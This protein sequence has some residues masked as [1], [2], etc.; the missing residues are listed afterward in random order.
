MTTKET[1]KIS[2]ANRALGETNSRT[3]ELVEDCLING[4]CGPDD[5]AASQETRKLVAYI[6]DAVSC[7]LLIAPQDRNQANVE[8]CQKQAVS[9]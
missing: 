5:G 2:K 6:V 4:N 8:N 3:L 7:I 1:Q 9:E